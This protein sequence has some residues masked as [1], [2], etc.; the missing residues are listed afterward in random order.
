MCKS[1]SLPSPYWIAMDL[2]NGV[3]ITIVFWYISGKLWKPS[4]NRTQVG[5]KFTYNEVLR[6]DCDPRYKLVGSNYR[7]CQESGLWSG[8]TPSC[9]RKCPLRYYLHL[10]DHEKTDATAFTTTPSLIKY[11]YSSKTNRVNI[12]QKCVWNEN[13]VLVIQMN[14]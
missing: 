6:F 3:C 12:F 10:S 2:Q 13:W 14:C 8:V 11:S 4:D 7:R 9:V 5:E 1:R